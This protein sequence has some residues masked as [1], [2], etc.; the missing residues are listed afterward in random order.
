MMLTGWPYGSG[1]GRRARVKV[2][3][4]GGSGQIRFEPAGLWALV[5]EGAAPHRIG[6]RGGR[7]VTQVRDGWRTGPFSHPGM[8]PLGNPIGKA[9]ND[10][11]ADLENN[12]DREIERVFD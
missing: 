6:G 9:T 11:E 4:T 1:G 3:N 2:S 10:I 8:S 12:T 5:Q 7:I